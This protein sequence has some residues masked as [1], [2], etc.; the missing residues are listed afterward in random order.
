MITKILQRRAFINGRI[1]EAG[2]EVDFDAGSPAGFAAAPSTPVGTLSV[3][4]LEAI[5]ARRKAAEAAPADGGHPAPGDSDANGRLTKAE[6]IA[7]LTTRGIAHDPAA[8]RDD[9]YAL[10]TETP[11]QA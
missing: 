10:L 2:E 5:L 6:I 8:K 7:E 9:L 4:E 11:P 1:H 3:E